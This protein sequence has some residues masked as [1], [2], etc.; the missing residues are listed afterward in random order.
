MVFPS[1]PKLY[2]SPKA[3]ANSPA[4]AERRLAS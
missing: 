3:A 4:D 2:T 1:S